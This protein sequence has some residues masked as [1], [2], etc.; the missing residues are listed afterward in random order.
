[1]NVYIDVWLDGNAGDRARAA[2]RWFDT[3]LRR[4]FSGNFS[5]GPAWVGSLAWGEDDPLEQ[6][7]GGVE[8]RDQ[9]VVELSRPHYWAQLELGEE[10]ESGRI[11]SSSAYFGGEF[12]SLS[13]ALPCGGRVMSDAS[14]C[15]EL[16]ECVTEAAST[17]N[18][19]FGRIEQGQSLDR[20]NLDI[21]LRRKRRTYLA[22]ARESLRGYAWV[23]VCPEELLDR[24]GGWERLA[25]VGAFHRVIPLAAGGAVL[26]ASETL[27]GYSDAVME[28]VFRTLSPVLPSGV[29]SAHVAFPGVRFFP[30]DARNADAR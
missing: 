17:V 7:S 30:E 22:E 20:A 5:S 2:A 16:V 28:G 23:T 26:Q 21:A 4:L 12:T 13:V 24:L 3:C 1:M 9:F 8:R 19:T 18:P 10:G 6:F 29:P 15:A 27:A 14:R 11:G 25:S